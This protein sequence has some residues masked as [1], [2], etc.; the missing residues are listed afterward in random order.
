MHLCSCYN[1]AFSRQNHEHFIVKI[2]NVQS[3]KHI[4]VCCYEGLD[5]MVEINVDRFF[6]SLSYETFKM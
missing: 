4:H 2:Q 5:F 3:P 1:A 6:L